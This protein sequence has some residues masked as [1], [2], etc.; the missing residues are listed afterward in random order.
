M[1]NVS[2]KYART[3][4]KTISRI[5]P[6]LAFTSTS[7]RMAPFYSASLSRI[8]GRSSI[9]IRLAERLH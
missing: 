5:S 9:L 3:A 1:R 6:S 8:M 2:R 7:T 4:L